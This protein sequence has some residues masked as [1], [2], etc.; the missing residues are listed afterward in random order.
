[1]LHKG[2]ISKRETFQVIEG[3]GLEPHLY[4]C[5]FNYMEWFWSEIIG[6]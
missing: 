1:M 3:I 5:G 2:L 6:S 4:S